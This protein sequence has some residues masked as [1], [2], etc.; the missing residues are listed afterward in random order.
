MSVPVEQPASVA[1]HAVSEDREA[2]IFWR[3][4][5]RMA[6]THLGQIFSSARL[7]TSLVVALSLFFWIGLFILFF[8]AFNFVKTHVGGAGAAYHAQ[9]FKLVFHLFFASLNVMLVFSS[10]IILYGTLFRSPETRLLMAMP[11]RDERIALHKFQEA[12]AFSCWGFFL[13]ASPMMLAYGVVVSAPWYYYALLLPMIF[14]FVYIPCSLGA[15]C[16]L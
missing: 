2:Q 10:G 8:Q 3:L 11:V 13:L 15:L 14:S 6:R 16:C 5:Y 7:R 12:V 9:T 1:R 4:R